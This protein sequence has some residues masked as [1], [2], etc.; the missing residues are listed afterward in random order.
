MERYE[1]SQDEDDDADEDEGR[2]R[3]E[4]VPIVEEELSV[5]TRKVA[6]GGARVTS[7]VTERPVEQTV[8]L[9]EE[10]VKAERRPADRART[11]TRPRPPSRRR[12]S[13]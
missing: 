9:R 8:S 10:R 3:G 4:T 13:R 7:S 2:G 11:R 6:N 12:R 1:A 5:G